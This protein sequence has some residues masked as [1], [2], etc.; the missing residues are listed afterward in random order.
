[1]ALV[2]AMPRATTVLKAPKSF[3]A[4]HTVRYVPSI[5]AANTAR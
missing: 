4:A 1:M 3:P 5:N 2:T